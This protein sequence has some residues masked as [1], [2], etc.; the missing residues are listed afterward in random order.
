MPIGASDTRYAIQGV[1]CDDPIVAAV[2][3][4]KIPTVKTWCIVTLMLSLL[5]GLAIKFRRVGVARG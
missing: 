4:A 1:D 2:C 5:G 3:A